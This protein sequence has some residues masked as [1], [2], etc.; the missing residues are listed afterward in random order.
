MKTDRYKLH[1]HTTVCIKVLQQERVSVFR[2][3]SKKLK[4]VFVGFPPV[5]LR[6]YRAGYTYM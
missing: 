3:I 5:P 6:T 4:I 1:R 2:N